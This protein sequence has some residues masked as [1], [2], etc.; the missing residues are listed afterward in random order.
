MI[1]CG[2]PKGPGNGSLCSKVDFG[3]AWP[4]ELIEV[5][6]LTLQALG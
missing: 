6:E 3:L 1:Q 4:V 2:S 5:V